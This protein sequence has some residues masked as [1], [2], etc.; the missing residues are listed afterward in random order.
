MMTQ[1]VLQPGR[2]PGTD[3]EPLPT[4]C[5]TRRRSRTGL[6]VLAALVVVGIISLLGG[7]DII[8]AER[9]EDVAS[10]SPGETT[11]ADPFDVTFLRAF[12]ATDLDPVI[13]PKSGKRLLL[14]SLNV[15]NTGKAMVSS[16]LLTRALDPDLPLTTMN[17][18]PDGQADPAELYR[19][20][21]TQKQGS[22]QPGL[23]QHLLAVWWQKETDPLPTE[24]TVTLSGYTY[25]ESFLSSDKFWSDR[26]AKISVTLPVEELKKR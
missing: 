5:T 9:D 10:V 6:G 23:P 12:H 17:N 13:R 18:E 3:D 20:Q 11:H 1:Q 26:E 14:I 25:R 16:T 4:A 24:V 15:V 7:W 22:F 21:D 19:F 8:L 2:E